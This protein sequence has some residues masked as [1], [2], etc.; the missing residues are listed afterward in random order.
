MSASRQTPQRSFVDQVMLFALFFT[1]PFI[2][3][4]SLSVG[5][6]SPV[7]SAALPLVPSGIWVLADMGEAS[8]EIKNKALGICGA[9]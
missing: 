8:T 7:S 5:I 6:L 9:I 4:G 2:L 1:P 3:E